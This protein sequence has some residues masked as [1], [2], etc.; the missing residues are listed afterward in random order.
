MLQKRLKDEQSE[1]QESESSSVLGKSVT[2]CFV[3]D[4]VVII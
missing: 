1:E 3:H 4:F 2:I